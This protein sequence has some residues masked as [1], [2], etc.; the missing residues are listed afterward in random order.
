MSLV[1]EMMPHN[2]VVRQSLLTCI[3]I[4]CYCLV[5][6]CRHI[7][8]RHYHLRRVSVGPLLLDVWL[9]A[10]AE[11]DIRKFLVVLLVYLF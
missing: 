6:K 8:R 7:G 9:T 1:S 4:Y 11:V 10:L 5:S 3:R 2:P